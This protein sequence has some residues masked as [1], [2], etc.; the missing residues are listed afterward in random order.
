MASA[1][2]LGKQRTSPRYRRICCEIYQLPPEVLFAHQDDPEERARLGLADVEVVDPHAGLGT[3]AGVVVG[4]GALFGAM[5]EV[6]EG[7]QEYLVVTGSRSRNQAYLEA[8]E[9]VLSER[10]RLVH[11]RVLFGEPHHQVLK[12]HLLRLLELR[13][14]KRRE[15]ASIAKAARRSSSPGWS[16]WRT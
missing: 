10:P 11:Y 7:A 9:R 16:R 12:D 8:I 6:V 14:S 3:P 15:I 5:L 4:A 2:E 13:D 1:W